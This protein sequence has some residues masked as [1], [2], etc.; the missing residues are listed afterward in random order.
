LNDPSALIEGLEKLDLRCAQAATAF[1]GGAYRSRFAAGFGHEAESLE[2]PEACR[3][4]ILEQS[5]GQGR[6]QPPRR[7]RACGSALAVSRTNRVRAI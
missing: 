4:C 3:E 2:I 6:R 7:I 1:T 5:G